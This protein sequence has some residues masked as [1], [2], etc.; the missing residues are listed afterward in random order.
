[1]L[2]LVLN[3]PKLY[4]HES[5]ASLH[6]RTC[7][8]EVETLFTMYGVLTLIPLHLL[9]KADYFIFTSTDNPTGG[10]PTPEQV[11]FASILPP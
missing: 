8:G 11:T 2:I 5:L 7:S 10:D 9:M 3:K 1:M 4:L 6:A